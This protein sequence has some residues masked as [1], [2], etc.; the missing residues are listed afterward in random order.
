[1]RTRLRV[2]QSNDLLLEAPAL[3]GH[4]LRKGAEAERLSEGG[5]MLGHG[6]HLWERELHGRWSD[7]MD[8]LPLKH[9]RLAREILDLGLRGYL[10]TLLLLD[11]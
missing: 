8:H 2:H 7:V 10:R 5:H 9:A 3:F 4:L 6:L 11:L 1:M